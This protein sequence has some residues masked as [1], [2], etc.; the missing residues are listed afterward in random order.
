MSAVSYGSS[1]LLHLWYNSVAEGSPSDRC[2]SPLFI[3]FPQQ[4]AYQM[5][6]GDLLYR[7]EK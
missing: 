4:E 2:K 5:N 1:N 3:G 6:G 7:V